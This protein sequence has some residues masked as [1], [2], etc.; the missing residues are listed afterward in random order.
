MLGRDDLF[1]SQ[2]FPNA[3]INLEDLIAPFFVKRRA[4]HALFHVVGAA[5]SVFDDGLHDVVELGY[6]HIARRHENL[7]L[8]DLGAR[9]VEALFDVVQI[10]NDV[11]GGGLADDA[12]NLAFLN[13]KGLAAVALD[14]RLAED[15]HRFPP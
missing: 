2:S 15:L 5:V 9:L 13:H 3:A 12:N 14:D 7:S 8:I 4:A 6:E 1:S 11:V 10:E